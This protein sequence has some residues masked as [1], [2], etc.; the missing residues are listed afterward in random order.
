MDQTLTGTIH[1]NTI[2]LDAPLGMPAGQRVEV[3]VRTSKPDSANG[4]R[5]E[6]E[7]APYWTPED[8]R[9]FEEIY[10]ARKYSTRQQ[11]SDELPP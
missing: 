4:N 11:I 1:G 5:P 8:D 6:D 10:Q 3:V 9:I 7:L 2:V